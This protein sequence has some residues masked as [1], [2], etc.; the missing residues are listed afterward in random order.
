M[1]RPFTCICM[2][3]AGGSG[4][5]LYE[6]KHRT[7]MLDQQIEQTLKQ[8]EATRSRIGILQAEWA[9]LNEPERLAELGDRFLTLKPVAPT[10]FVTLSELDQHLPAPLP[11][12]AVTASNPTQPPAAPAA[13]EP[14][15]VAEAPPREEA[16]QVALNAAP[17]HVETARSRP[18]APAHPAAAEPAVRPE[19]KARMQTAVARRAPRSEAFIQPAAEATMPVVHPLVTPALA[20]STPRPRPVRAEPSAPVIPTGWVPRGT[21]SVMAAAPSATGSLL[22]G[23]HATMAAPV[24]LA[25][26]AAWPSR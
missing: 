26:P 5:Y 17:A 11:P 25:D 1:I 8:A 24:P 21:R 3:L 16:P 22:G 20:L 23:V 9:L 13:E 2:L 19:A 7:L 10:Q 15:P 4:L 14:P 18:A 6:T 12:P